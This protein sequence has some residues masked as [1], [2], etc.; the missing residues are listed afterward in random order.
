[1]QKHERE[2]ALLKEKKRELKER[3]VPVEEKGDDAF[4]A[5]P[6]ASPRKRSERMLRRLRKEQ[7][8]EEKRKREA[9]E[10]EEELEIE[11]INPVNRLTDA[12]GQSE[13]QE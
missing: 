6:G 7:E 2:E 10:E 4:T 11:V 9:G 8:E 13:K 1:M 3:G 12:N 5:M